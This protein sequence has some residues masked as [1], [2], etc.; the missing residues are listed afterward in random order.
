MRYLLGELCANLRQALGARSR[1][2]ELVCEAE[3]LLLPTDTAIPLTLFTVEAVTNAFRHAF[4]TAGRGTVTLVLKASDG[5][6]TLTVA[7]TGTGFDPP[8]VPAGTGM[9]LLRAFSQQLAG[10]LA[11]DSAPGRSA[12]IS[13]V[14][15]IPP[16]DGA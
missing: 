8:L 9:R 1:G 5:M 3:E 2:I 10:T 6:A 11:I 15:P 14:F 16:K 4:G 7:D 13:L 12:T